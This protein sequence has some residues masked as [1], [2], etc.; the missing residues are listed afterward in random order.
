[1]L[2]RTD[3]QVLKQHWTELR[4]LY[5]LTSCPKLKQQSS[6]DQASKITFSSKML[7][8]EHL[9]QSLGVLA[10]SAPSHSWGMNMAVCRQG[11]G[12]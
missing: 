10:G 6:G 3:T 12:E 2:A 11:G 8:M 9:P 5:I 7:N 1:M 4:E